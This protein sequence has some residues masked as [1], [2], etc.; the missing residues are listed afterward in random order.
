MQRVH[1]CR[2]R[3]AK[4]RIVVEPPEDASTKPPVAHNECD[5]P[6]VSNTNDDSDSDDDVYVPQGPPV[7][8]PAVP[9]PAVVPVVQTDGIGQ[10]GA[11]PDDEPVVQTDGIEQPATQPD[12]EPADEPAVNEQPTLVQ[13]V[14]FHDNIIHPAHE[15][16]DAPPMD[17]L[18]AD[19]QLDLFEATDKNT[20]DHQIIG[21]EI[22]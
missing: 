11:H 9:T 7:I 2:V 16:V 18:L 10:P 14:D 5:V 19:I 3:S 15:Q 20:S 4:P 22:L 21:Q 6:K 17:L 1:T 12:D 8:V 13:A